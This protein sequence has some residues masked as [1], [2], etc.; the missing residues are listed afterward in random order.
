MCERRALWH[1]KYQG[2][3]TYAPREKIT[4]VVRGKK[5][6]TSR[7]LFPRYIFVWIADHWH[8]LFSTIGISKVLMTGDHPARLPDKWVE[9]MRAREHHGLI[10]LPKHRFR[11][12]QRVVVASGLL[13]GAHG[14]YQGMGH[15]QREIVLLESLGRVELASGLLR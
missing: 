9:A 12:G 13:L 14:L 8:A 7:W 2:F 3:T 10:T 4:R 15:Q 11:I 1:M 5:Q 6:N